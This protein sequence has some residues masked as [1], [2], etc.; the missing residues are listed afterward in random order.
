M[1]MMQS[2]AVDN[3]CGVSATVA[4]AAASELV[5]SAVPDHQGVPAIEQTRGDGC[6]HAPDACDTDLQWVLLHS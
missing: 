1:V 5:F 6:T 3:S 2:A 4:P